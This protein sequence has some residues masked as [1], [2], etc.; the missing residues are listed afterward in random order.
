MKKLKR[1]TLLILG[2]MVAALTFSGGFASAN[3]KDLGD[4][5]EEQYLL[6][7]KILT[8]IEVTIPQNNLY[9]VYNADNRLVF[10]TRNTEDQKLKILLNKSD[11]LTTINNTHY[12]K[13]SR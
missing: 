4:I 10:E 6:A 7:E 12:Y 2:I 1:A 11:L 8:E 13:L 3:P 9:K 5:E